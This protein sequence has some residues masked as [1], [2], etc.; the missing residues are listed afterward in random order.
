MTKQT[1]QQLLPFLKEIKKSRISWQ[2]KARLLYLVIVE[3]N[4]DKVMDKYYY[5]RWAKLLGYR[6]DYLEEY[7]TLGFWLNY[8]GF[9]SMTRQESIKYIKEYMKEEQIKCIEFGKMIE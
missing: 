3:L 2:A 5:K 9:D 6:L 8:G 1:L 4:P 7:L